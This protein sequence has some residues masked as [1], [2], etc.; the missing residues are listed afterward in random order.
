MHCNRWLV[1]G[2]M[3]LIAI[4]AGTAE[5][6]KGPTKA[7]GSIDLTDPAGDVSPIHTSDG[8]DYPGF[9]IVKLS[10]K[11]DGKQIA[12]VA[13]L[14]DPPGAFASDVV[15]LLFDTD[16]NAKSGAMF[17]FPKIGGFEYK[18]EL[19]ACVDY[20]DRSSA[21]AGGSKAKPTVHWAAV[22]LERYKGK[23]QFDKDAVVDDMGFPGRKPSPKAPITGNVVQ[24]SFDYHDLNVKPGQTIR[25][26]I[27][28]SHGND[29]D[30]GYFPEVLL[31]LK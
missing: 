11:S 30:D 7:A 10:I 15:E 20:A 18:G 13:T 1:A 19:H 23:G 14:K 31:T 3:A 28:E 27:K 8:V 9:D 24:G 5:T 12:V 2:A 22:N 29:A 21:C 26:L 4:S 25:L 17:T 16:N 6:K